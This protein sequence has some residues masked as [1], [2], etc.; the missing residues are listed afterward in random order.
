MDHLKGLRLERQTGSW[1]APFTFGADTRNLLTKWL[2]TPQIECLEQ[3]VEF[4]LSID[5]ETRDEP[6]LQDSK[7]VLSRIQELAHCL[8]VALT[9]A[10][11]PASATL[12][13]VSHKYL[14]DYRKLGSLSVGLDL[15]SVGLKEQ[16]SKFPNQKNQ[17]PRC[18][19]MVSQIADVL[20][21]LGIRVSHSKTSRFYK[22]AHIVLKAANIPGDQTRSIMAIT[23]SKAGGK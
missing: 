9:N 17:S 4:A 11:Q 18:V 5:S 14:D 23:K 21:P 2:S 19:F 10:P 16:I 13:L 8:S 15:L 12:D 1:V 7:K 3:E 6:T 20:E 22:I